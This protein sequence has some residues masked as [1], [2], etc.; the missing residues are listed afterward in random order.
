[1]VDSPIGASFSAATVTFTF[2]SLSLALT[3][4]EEGVTVP[5]LSPLKAS[6]TS[7]LKSLLRSTVTSISFFSPC[8][9][10]VVV[11]GAEMRKVSFF[12]APVTTFLLSAFL[13]PGP[14]GSLLLHPKVT[15]NAETIRSAQLFFITRYPHKKARHWSGHQS[16]HWMLKQTT[17]RLPEQEVKCAMHEYKRGKAENPTRR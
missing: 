5:P 13:A 11:A 17:C 12:G 7:C 8:F 10:V 16:F 9:R 1:M 14:P 3:V 2:V 6:V 4:A 15:T